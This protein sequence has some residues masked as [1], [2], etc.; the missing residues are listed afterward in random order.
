[1]T[2]GPAYDFSSCVMVQSH[3]LLAETVLPG[4]NLSLLLGWRCA[5]RNPLG[6]LGTLGDLLQEAPSDQ[7][8]GK[9]GFSGESG[10]RQRPE[11]E[12]GWSW[13]RVG[14]TAA[15]RAPPSCPGL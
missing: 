2:E 1:M 3:T 7:R 11:E 15:S 5:A 13:A 12:R 6:L 4:V 9:I 14:E 8:S 10:G